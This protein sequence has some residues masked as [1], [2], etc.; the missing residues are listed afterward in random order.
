MTLPSCPPSPW[1]EFLLELDSMLT[2]AC[3]LPIIGGYA[4]TQ[5]YG[6]SR[7]TADI[8]VLEV[9]P[10]RLSRWLQDAAGIG[11][12]LAAKHRIYL[13]IVGAGVANP[14]FDYESRLRPIYDGFFKHL[15][16]AV[17]DPY[18]VALTKLKRDS[19]KDFQDVLRLAAAVPFDLDEFER[20]Y[21]EELRENTTGRPEDN[22]EV[23]YR[24]KAAI[25]ESRG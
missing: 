22:D 14:P 21:L 2:D 20:R 17:M 24:W 15:H 16:L 6:A 18:D 9:R 5:I 8:D 4:V 1:G 3:H 25:T 13:D 10:T 19:D 11:S 12:I 23:F 7:P